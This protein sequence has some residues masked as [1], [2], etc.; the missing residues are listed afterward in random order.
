[1]HPRITTG[2]F[3]NYST[4]GQASDR[5]SGDAAAPP[6][7]WGTGLAARAFR[8]FALPF[9]LLLPTR[10][11]ARLRTEGLEHLA[12]V[13][14]P[15]IFA[16]NHR[17]H[18]DT[19]ALL[20]AAPPRWRYRIAPSM[21]DCYFGGAGFGL[22]LQNEF[23]Y[24]CTVLYL[25]AFT[26]P[27]SPVSLR[28]A[29]RHVQQLTRSGWSILIYP[30]GERST[31]ER[32]LPFESGVGMLAVQLN[33]PVI[34]VHIDGSEEILPRSA[35]MFRFGSVRVRFGAPISPQGEDYRNLTARVERAIRDL[36]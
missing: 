31:R 20:T 15:V 12:G 35:K 25:N 27:R 29:L 26:L 5:S 23:K 10:V 11:F 32:L 2:E 28:L 34:P 24:F 8:R 13:A 14:G 36:A 22:R 9:V 3:Q 6:S 19:Y 1:M 4:G 30:E 7:T 18:F 33:L 17:S 21:C 16:A